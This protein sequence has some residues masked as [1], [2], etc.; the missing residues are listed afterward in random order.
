MKQIET[1]YDVINLVAVALKNRERGSTKD[2]KEALAIVKKWEGL[3]AGDIPAAVELIENAHS[4]I[5]EYRYL[6][7]FKEV[8]SNINCL[9]PNQIPSQDS[10]RNFTV[11]HSLCKT[12]K[13]CDDKG[14]RPYDPMKDAFSK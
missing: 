5:R 8:I 11:F 4:T 7:W 3:Y 6:A 14:G 12:G 9:K 13:R 1:I 2:L 10:V